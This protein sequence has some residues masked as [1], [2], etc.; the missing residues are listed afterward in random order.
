M[1]RFHVISFLWTQDFGDEV[2]WDL[3]LRLPI[4]HFLDQLH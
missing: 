3:S 1:I 4:L 2:D